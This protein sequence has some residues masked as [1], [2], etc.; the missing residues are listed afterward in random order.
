MKLVIALCVALAFPATAGAVVGV[1]Y[2]PTT[3]LTVNGDGAADRVFVTQVG[4]GT[5]QPRMQVEPIGTSTSLL[6]G[7]G[8]TK[9]GTDAHCPITGNRFQTIRMG[10]GAD[11]VRTALVPDDMIVDGGGGNDRLQSGTGF[12]QMIGGTGDDELTNQGGND[13]MT[14]GDGNDTFAVAIGAPTT[15]M[16]GEAGNDT[17]RSTRTDGA[18]LFDGG[19]GSDTADYSAR[20]DALS[21]STTFGITTTPDDGAAG[22]GDDLDNVETLI[23]GSAGDTLQVSASPLLSTPP[24]ITFVLRGNGGADTLRVS[25]RL[26]ANLD[27]GLGTD[28]VSGGAAADR[29]F[30][31]EGEVDT[32]TCGGGLDT[33]TPDLRDMPVAEDCENLDQSDRREGPN[34]KIATR[35]VR[36]AA[37]GTLRVRLSCP[38]GLAIGCRGAAA[39]RVERARSRFGRAVSYRLRAGRSATLTLRLPAGQAA[40]ARRRGARVR[41]RSVERGVHGPKTT[42]R[43]IVTRR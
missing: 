29:I 23:G 20:S 26:T 11:E 12:D 43:S 35:P 17:L 28:S 30:S 41:V 7:A 6:V 27:A 15:T 10:D 3:G 33:Y 31:R 16:R 22:E 14:G 24:R 9:S 19:P 1:S 18:T 42:Q 25:G 32:I 40:A 4:N 36:V 39:V 21:L 37:D 34:V 38:R 8:C 5:P 13:T 2:D